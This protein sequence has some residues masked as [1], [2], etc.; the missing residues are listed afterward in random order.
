MDNWKKY[1]AENDDNLSI[2]DVDDK[3][4]QNVY[5]AAVP[6]NR[7]FFKKIK[8]ALESLFTKYGIR[9]EGYTSKRT[10]SKF[11]LAYSF[12]LVAFVF[13]SFAFKVKSYAKY[14]D[15]VTF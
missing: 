1:M 3:V 12:V 2:E 5:K 15:M 10:N 7:S 11:K 14:G 4:W 8:I 9:R 6:K 13:A